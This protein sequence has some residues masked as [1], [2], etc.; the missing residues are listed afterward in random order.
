[1]MPSKHSKKREYKVYLLPEADKE[2]KKLPENNQEKII[3]IIHSLKFPYQIPATRMRNKKN[4]YRT[5][6]GNYRILYKIY[7]KDIVVII[8]KISHRK[9]AYR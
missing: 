8:I 6:M 5:K 3:D 9:K 2:L 4:T 1:M 7:T